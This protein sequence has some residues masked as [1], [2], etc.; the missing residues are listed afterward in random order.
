MELKKEL[1]ILKDYMGGKDN[2]AFEKQASFICK[3]F[4]SE[5]DQ[6]EIDH[7]IRSELSSISNRVE[8]AVKDAEIRLKQLLT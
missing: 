2:E 7:F 3:N 8:D 5:P 6:R 4:T 1:E